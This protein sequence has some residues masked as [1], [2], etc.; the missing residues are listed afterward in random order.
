MTDSL[1]YSIGALALLIGL[2]LYNQSVQKSHSISGE[3]IFTGN[4]E[5]VFRVVI[6]EFDKSVELVR[7]DSTWTISQADTLLIKENQIKNLFDRLLAVE[8]EMLITS[9]DEKW[10]KFGVDDSLGRHL[11]VYGEDDQELLHYIF[12]NSGQDYQHNYIRESKSSDVYR[13]NDNVYFLVNSNATYWGK[14]SP[15]PEQEE[16]EI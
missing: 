11:Q 5:D 8:Q 14:E 3:S 12:G 16:K 2:F 9:K 1:K 10:E 15:K 13:T 7:A 4:N 6:S